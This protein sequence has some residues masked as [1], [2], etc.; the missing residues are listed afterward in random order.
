MNRA[1]K[2]NCPSVANA[3]RPRPVRTDKV[4]DRKNAKSTIGLAT[5]RSISTNAARAASATSAA[6]RCDPSAD[7][8][9]ALD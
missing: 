8:A 6:T 7:P 1:R 9:I 2:K 5:R 4:R 3:R